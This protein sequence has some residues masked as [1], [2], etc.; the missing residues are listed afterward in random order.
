VSDDY[1]NVLRIEANPYNRKNMGDLGDLAASIRQNGVLQPITVCAHPAKAGL[2]MILYGER[3]W[4]AA[5][6]A[7]LDEVPAEIRPCPKPHELL[8]LMLVEN[9]HRKDQ[10]P[11]ETAEMMGLLR[12]RGYSQAMISVKTGLSPS[13]VSYHMRLL[14]LDE[15]SRQ[16]VRDKLVGAGDAHAAIKAERARR[17]GRPAARKVTVAPDYFSRAH[18]LAEEAKMRCATA[19]HGGKKY[20]RQACGACWEA[21]IRDDQSSHERAQGAL[22]RAS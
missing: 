2:F 17:G 3:R 12:S 20:G 18:P 9:C 8:C 1:L 16:R 14:E 10:D 22:V 7:G 5:Q 11:I 15:T 21:A 13:T 19:G 6:L 4:R